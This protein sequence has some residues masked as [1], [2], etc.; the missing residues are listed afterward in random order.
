[1]VIVD[2]RLESFAP[3]FELKE[4]SPYYR[5]ASA[6][7]APSG[8][9]QDRVNGGENG[10]AAPAFAGSRRFASVRSRIAGPR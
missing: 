1:M 10:D 4:K 7:R 6:N 9:I 3:L 2:G 8:L 5:S